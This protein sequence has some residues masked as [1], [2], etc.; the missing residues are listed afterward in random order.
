MSK[1]VIE[2]GVLPSLVGLM[3]CSC[4]LLLT[5]TTA[6]AQGSGAQPDRAASATAA[7]PAAS[8]LPSAAEIKA[9]DLAITALN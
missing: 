6:M 1:P 2:H 7:V 3:L 9:T 5:A 8:P 4:V